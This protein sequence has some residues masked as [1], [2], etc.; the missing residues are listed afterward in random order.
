MFYTKKMNLPW[1]CQSHV[2]AVIII[3]VRFISIPSVYSFVPSSSLSCHRHPSY[4]YHST[5]RFTIIHSNDF[6]FSSCIGKGS[7]L[8]FQDRGHGLFST[9][10]LVQGTLIG[11]ISMEDE[12]EDT[13]DTREKEK[14][15]TMIFV[16]QGGVIQS[17]LTNV[18]TVIINGQIRGDI[19]C[20]KLIVGST[21]IVLGNIDCSSLYV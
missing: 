19:S 2:V 9:S 13:K 16:E 11:N 21:G 20:V 3:I 5:I 1:V 12:Y 6:E 4:K 18:H 10:L 14:E 8:E 7:Y 15:D 17:N